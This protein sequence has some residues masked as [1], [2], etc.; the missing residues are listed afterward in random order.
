MSTRSVLAGG[1]DRAVTAQ[2]SLATI[3]TMIRVLSSVFQLSAAGHK[4]KHASD[5][6]FPF[7]GTIRPIKGHICSG[8]RITFSVTNIFIVVFESTKEPHELQEE[9]NSSHTGFA[10]R[11]HESRLRSRS[12][13][14]C[15]SQWVSAEA[16][17]IRSVR[18][19]LRSTETRT[20]SRRTNHE[21]QAALG[22]A[23]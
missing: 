1:K 3:A 9:N 21:G 5:A 18:R 16:D 10:V 13:P 17:W 15:Y 8:Q 19:R 2:F 7:V 12:S 14:G 22:R 6:I 11:T 4:W 23:L 20:V